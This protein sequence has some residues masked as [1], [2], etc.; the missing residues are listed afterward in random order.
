[1]L[2]S[3]TFASARADGI[4]KIGVNGHGAEVEKEEQESSYGR[5]WKL[6]TAKSNVRRYLLQ[7]PIDLTC[8]E[9]RLLG[10]SH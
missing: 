2:E 6:I 7:K 1:M 3:F 4:P 10:G 9:G 8:Y 5:G